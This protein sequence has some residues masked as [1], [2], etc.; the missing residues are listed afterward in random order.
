MHESTFE[1][2]DIAS[3]LSHE[4]DMLDFEILSILG[5][6]SIK[7]QVIPAATFTLLVS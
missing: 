2:H 4:I 3:K 6:L 7:S 5:I 1:E